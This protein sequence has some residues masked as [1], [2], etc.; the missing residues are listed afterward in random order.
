M[1]YVEAVQGQDWRE[2]GRNGKG[3]PPAL[4]KEPLF[5]QAFS[6]YIIPNHQAGNPQEFN[7]TFT[8]TGPT[9]VCRMVFAQ[10]N[11]GILAW[12]RQRL[13]PSQAVRPISRW[14]RWDWEREKGSSARD[15]LM[16]QWAQKIQKRHS[17][18]CFRFWR[19]RLHFLHT[20]IFIGFTPHTAT[21][22]TRII[23]FLVGNPYKPLFV[24]V[25]GLG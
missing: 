11:R 6:K 19:H 4:R 2:W 17:A 7:Q 12:R 1:G 3:Q 15:Y 14:D 9:L 23:T 16:T 10:M 22:A 21:V 5:S 24:T 18:T 8:K 20:H 13:W 25:T